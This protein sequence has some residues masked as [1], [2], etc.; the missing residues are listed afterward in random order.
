M[1]NEVR[2]S[3]SLLS[4]KKAS[5]PSSYNESNNKNYQSEKSKTIQ[6]LIN[7]RSAKLNSKNRT[8]IKL[9]GRKGSIL[10]KIALIFK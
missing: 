1:E 3:E 7:E 9:S 10:F 6:E 4:F 5:I 8:R 2:M